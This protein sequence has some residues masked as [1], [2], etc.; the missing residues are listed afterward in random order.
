[1]PQAR[2]EPC[3]AKHLPLRYLLFG[4]PV[5]V[6][7]SSVMTTGSVPPTYSIIMVITWLPGYLPSPLALVV[8]R[9]WHGTSYRWLLNLLSETCSRRLSLYCHCSG[10][11][12]HLG[13]NVT[14]LPS[15]QGT[16]VVSSLYQAITDAVSRAA[17]DCGRARALAHIVS[18]GHTPQNVRRGLVSCLHYS[19]SHLQ[20]HTLV[21]MLT[22]YF[23][24]NVCSLIRNVGALQVD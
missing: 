23:L 20:E 21:S 11:L 15:Y 1:M 17:H 7:C 19:R 8:N 10:F 24:W 13:Q 12:Y 18:H 22:V 14:R 5:G 9:Y 4:R 3:Q 2:Q 16:E 6:C